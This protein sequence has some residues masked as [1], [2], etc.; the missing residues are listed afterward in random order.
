MVIS[1]VDM[2]ANECDLPMLNHTGLIVKIVFRRS[3]V[4]GDLA[5]GIEQS[6]R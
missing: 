6:Q 2:D 1:N 4:D 5:T 3:I